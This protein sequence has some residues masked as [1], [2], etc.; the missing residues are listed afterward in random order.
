MGQKV[1]PINFRIGV[2]K[3]W[4]SRWF[5][6]GVDYRKLLF[7]DIK[8]RQA[9]EEKFRLAGVHSVEIERLPKAMTVR[10]SVSRPGIVIGRGG[11]GIEETKS[12]ILK[13]LGH[14]TKNGLAPKID[15]IVEQVK[16][17]ELSA[18]LV[19]QRIAGELERRMP[20]RRVITRTIERVM[21]AGAQGIRVKLAGRIEGAEIA[22]KE[23]YQEG[24]VPTQSLRV[25]IDY[26]EQKALLKRGY[27]GIK[28][29]INSPEE[30]R[31]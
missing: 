26:A 6:K 1:N 8:L 3:T 23:K 9:L 5:A 15:I 30:K 31:N 28:V 25:N 20:H 7:E 11:S 14:S 17:P 4:K 2:V 24:S 19:A 22:R 12:F 10:I 21:A 18:R 13:T 16:S 29:W 27:V